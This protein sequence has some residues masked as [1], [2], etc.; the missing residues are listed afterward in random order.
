[1]SSAPGL[2]VRTETE[3]PASRSPRASARTDQPAPPARGG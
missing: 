2:V 1:M 3:C